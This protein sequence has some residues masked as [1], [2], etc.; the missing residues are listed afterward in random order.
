[1]SCAPHYHFRRSGQE[2]RAAR[3]LPF[4]NLIFEFSL[5]FVAQ[6]ETDL[7]ARRVT[8]PAL[9]LLGR[10]ARC[11]NCT[12]TRETSLA[13]NAPLI[14]DEV[15]QVV[16]R[17]EARSDMVVWQNEFLLDLQVSFRPPRTF[18]PITDLSSSQIWVAFKVWIEARDIVRIDVNR[19]AV[20]QA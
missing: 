16:D 19:I 13:Q 2:K 15:G 17:H 5:E 10:C 4:F 11:I 7:I 18:D 14:I 6:T 9:A 3:K 12:L 20:R 8:N 1:M